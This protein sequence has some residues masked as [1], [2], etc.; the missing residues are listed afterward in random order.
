M[1]VED[2]KAMLAAAE[3]PEQNAAAPSG[4]LSAAMG[5]TK[6]P[7]IAADA[8]AESQGGGQKTELQ[9]IMSSHRK[10]TGRKPTTH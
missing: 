10:A 6:Q 3:V 1:S 5:N 2:A 8:G 4:L 7:E 9:E